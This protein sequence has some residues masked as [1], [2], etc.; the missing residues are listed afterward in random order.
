MEIRVCKREKM[1]WM[2]NTAIPTSPSSETAMAGAVV[3]DQYR[4]H[5]HHPAKVQSS[6]STP[7]KSTGETGSQPVRVHMK[8][9]ATPHAWNGDCSGYDQDM[10][11]KVVRPQQ[12]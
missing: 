4:P 5:E 7:A 9:R 2:K 11:M 8:Q 10:A 1:E 3:P 6:C 12:D